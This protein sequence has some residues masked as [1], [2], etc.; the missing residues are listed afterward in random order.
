M[1][2]LDTVICLLRI[3]YVSLIILNHNIFLIYLFIYVKIITT[4]YSCDDPSTFVSFTID[5]DIFSKGAVSVTMSFIYITL[6]HYVK[7]YFYLSKKIISN[8]T[9]SDFG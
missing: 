6:L 1:V 8:K 5:V 7:I 3:N 2:I 9:T 4:P